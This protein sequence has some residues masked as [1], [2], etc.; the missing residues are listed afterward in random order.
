MY[1]DTKK[2]WVPEARRVITPTVVQMEAVE[3]GAAALSIILSYYGRFIPLEQ[4]RSDCGVSRDGSKASSIVIAAKNHGLNALGFHYELE[5]LNQVKVPFIVF[6]NFNHFLVVE[7]FSKDQV[8]LNDPATGPRSVSL[9]EFDQSYTGVVL[10]FEPTKEFIPQGKPPSIVNSLKTRM[11][12]NYDSIL[13][14][15]LI[16][17]I[18]VIPGLLIPTFTKIY[19]DD[20]LIGEMRDW[21][22]PII[23]G[24]IITGIGKGFLI[25]VQNY[26]LVRFETKLDL[27]DSSRYFWHILH[28]PMQF[29]SQRGTGDL[30][31]RIL[32][33]SKIATSISRDV[34]RTF[35]NMFVAS[36]YLVLMFI[37][38]TTLTLFTLIIAVINFVVLKKIMKIRRDKSL[39]IGI[40]NGQFQNAAYNGIDSIETLKASGRENDYFNK[41]MG[42]QVK[43]INAN[44]ELQER[45]IPFQTAP[46]L[47]NGINTLIIL[48]IGSLFIIQGHMSIGMLIAFQSLA[49]GFLTPVNDLVSITGVIQELSGD[50]AKVDD[51]MEAES[52][53]KDSAFTGTTD[54]RKFEGYLSL[55]NITFGYNVTQKPLFH[56][57]S[58]NISPG[59]R[60]A[61]IGGSGSGKSTIAKLICRLYTPWEGVIIIDDEPI[62]S[63]PMIEY[64]GSV[65]LVDQ[66]IKLFKGS[67]ADNITM[68]DPS[69]T[70]Q[71]M[72]R[73]AKDA[74]I[75]EVIT[76]RDNGYDTGVSEDGTNFSGGQRQRIE[77]ARA[78][79]KNPRVLIMDEATSALDPVTE[80]LISN[81]IRHRGCT[82]IIIAHRLST[83]R[84][85]DEIIVLDKGE[86]VER[87]THEE[88]LSLSGHY[89]RLIKMEAKS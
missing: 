14:L 40:T 15:L 76:Q 42:I 63:I 75:H 55:E 81:N 7:G 17:I 5:Q 72:I 30:S 66:E 21:L 82:C 38:T 80:E 35:L 50:M 88:L 61:L 58:L 39:Q 31:N 87:G 73:A 1:S 79:A 33:N 44:Q 52:L 23:F 64:A 27:R 36:F 54:A 62:T 86:V 37:Y 69:I 9:Y 60:I 34:S 24:L 25:W 11:T 89:S 85:C 10:T 70:E 56:D 59:K 84:D 71:D 8:F 6:W 45:T 53:P 74:C 32:L 46:L 77:I 48:G 26:Y 16:G 12:K 49:A 19:I 22:R 4:L 28:L 68:W 47:L 83:I 3:C 20:Y 67:I 18:L 51:V 41:L 29:F 2:T 13:Y 57:F 78:L 65:S 43:I